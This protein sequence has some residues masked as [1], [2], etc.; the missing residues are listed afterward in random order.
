MAEF[1]RRKPLGALWIAVGV[2]I[3]G[4]LVDLQWHLTH[5][6][7][8]GASEQ[9]RAHLVL[10]IGVLLI[11]LVTA[12]AVKRGARGF[13]YRI[14]LAGAVVYVPVATW[15]FVE[16]AN[17]SDPESA[18]VLIGIAYAAM[19]IGVITATVA[20]WRRRPDAPV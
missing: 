9:V 20:A 8:E 6:E 12:L 11:L 18:H 5:D 14:A 16:H 1:V 4:R 7:F 2:V 19:L 13:G 15:H 17:G 3:I 10:W